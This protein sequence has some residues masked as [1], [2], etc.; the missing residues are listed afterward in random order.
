MVGFPSTKS[1]KYHTR[2][3]SL[4]SRPHPL[5]SQCDEHLTRLRDYESTPASSTSSISQQLSGLEDLHECV[6]KLLL[7]PS[8]QEA[9]VRHCGEKWVDELLDGSLRLLDMCSSA[10]DALIHTKECVRELRSAIRRRSEMTN[11]IKKYLASRKVVKR[12]I[13]KALDTNKSIERKSDTTVDGNDYDTTAMVSLLKEVEATGLRMFESLLFLIS[14]KK[15]KTKSSWSILSV[16]NSKREVCPEVD[17]E[18]NEFSNMD[19]ALN[20]VIC[21]KTN[22][23]KDTTQVSENVQNHLE[24]LDLSTQDLEQT[25]ER[26]F[27]RLIKTRVS[28]LNIL[29]N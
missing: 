10:K 11:E 4:P 25:T 24:K 18:F 22:K 13:Q 6:E 1:T 21:Q 14:G 19:N 23:C 26:L 15:T 5:F 29:N 28:L 3:N 16:M 7:V 12:A 9:F 27:R 2:S 8:I 17:A 20:S